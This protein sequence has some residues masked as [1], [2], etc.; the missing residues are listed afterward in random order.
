MYNLA[1]IYI[2]NDTIKD[3]DNEAVDLLIESSENFYYSQILLSLFLIKKFGFDMKIIKSE[4]ENKFKISKHLCCKL[5]SIINNIIN[6]GKILYNY[7]FDSYR[8]IDFLY[9]VELIDIQTSDLD[10]IDLNQNNRSKSYIKDITS[11]FY[12]GFGHDLC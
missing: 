5:L 7:L 1:H 10:R 4:F 6:G 9:N 8:K 2:Y 3:K 11:E 12:N